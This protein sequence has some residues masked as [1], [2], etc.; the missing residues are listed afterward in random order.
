MISLD[1]SQNWVELM[2]G[3]V[4]VLAVVGSRY[5]QPKMVAIS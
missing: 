4:L 5:A 1:V 2:Y 3:A